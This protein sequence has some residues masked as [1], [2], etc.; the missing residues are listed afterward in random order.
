MGHIITLW[1]IQTQTLLVALCLLIQI[2]ICTK[3]WQCCGFL[4]QMERYVIKDDENFFRDYI[5]VENG[6]V[7]KKGDIFGI[8]CMFFTRRCL[9]PCRA[10]VAIVLFLHDVLVKNKK[11]HRIF[12]EEIV[13]QFSNLGSQVI[14]RRLDF[15][16]LW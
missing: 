6:Q 14:Q 10:Q 4:H 2:K 5:L 8:I 15:Y 1:T 16:K 11:W 9:E 12:T 13:E 7:V 3:Q